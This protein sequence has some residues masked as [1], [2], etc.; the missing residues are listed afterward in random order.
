M[1][2]FYRV[3]LFLFGFSGVLCSGGIFIANRRS[4]FGPFHPLSLIFVLAALDVFVPAICWSVSGIREPYPW[5]EP[6]SYEDVA[7]GVAFYVVGYLGLAF[8]FLACA[9]SGCDPEVRSNWRL[10]RNVFWSL[11]LAFLTLS[12]LQLWL[13]ISEYGSVGDWL[14]YKLR[15]R[16]EGRL[17]EQP[18]PTVWAQVLSYLPVRQLF[19]LIVLVGFFHRQEMRKRVTLGVLFPLLATGLAITTFY[20]GS[21]L[22]LML[23]LAFV[24][25][26]RLRSLGPYSR[27]PK[28]G[29]PGRNANFVMFI[30]LG[31]VLFVVYGGI[32]RHLSA[33]AW[34]A[35]KTQASAVYVYSFWSHGSGLF[36]ISS[37]IR[38]YRNDTPLLVGKTYI[39][40]LLLPIP[41]SVYT[42]KP[43]WYGISDITRAMGWPKTTQSSVTIPGE[44]FA[45]F[46]WYGVLCIPLFG[47][48]FARLYVICSRS[49]AYLVFL[50]PA[51]VLYI[52]IIAN[53]MSSSGIMTQ[54][55]ALA[56]SFVGL[57][58][59][60]Q[61]TPR[62]EPVGIQKDGSA[63]LTASK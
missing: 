27:K 7:I 48:I 12:L 23:G 9:P 49:S 39:D 52:L 20:R 1:M 62:R 4:R 55:T 14:W 31:L 45:N 17:R 37:I 54:F 24:E 21:I 46:S 29:Q 6:V 3:L 19:N 47:V 36:G 32:R 44:A 30:L 53:W 42:T 18:W 33:K 60:F 50:Y 56:F 25:F 58:A 63:C 15:V 16:W 59:M 8:G 11:L 40:M 57:R 38:D 10:K 28:A 61:R 2:V 22:V 51:V 26:I 43:E 5:A 41:R 34:Q 35:Q 13:Q